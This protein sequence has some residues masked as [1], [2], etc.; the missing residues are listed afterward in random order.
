MYLSNLGAVRT[1]EQRLCRVGEEFCDDTCVKQ[2]IAYKQSHPDVDRC[3]T[4]AEQHRAIDICMQWR[5]GVITA[6]QAQAQLKPILDDP[7]GR[8]MRECQSGFDGWAQRLPNDAAC[9]T[10]EQQ[11]RLVQ[12]CMDQRMGRLAPADG[13]ALLAAMVDACEALPPPAPPQPAPP[14][15]VQPPAEPPLQMPPIVVADPGGDLPGAPGPGL[16]QVY[17]PDVS[18]PQHQEPSAIRKWGPVVG[19]LLIVGGAVYLLR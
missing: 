15:P 8:L 14:P 16:E 13:A 5:A 17:T 4:L 11:R 10:P 19:V 7:C 3:V 12:A 6:A 2:M 18:P 9:L 1:L